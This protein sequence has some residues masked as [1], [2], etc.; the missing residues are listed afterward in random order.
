MRAKTCGSAVATMKTRKGYRAKTR[1]E[2]LPGMGLETRQSTV[3]TLRKQRVEEGEAA[4]PNET[5]YRLG[6][7][8]DHPQEP[9][10]RD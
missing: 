7:E 5:G 4:V 6:E 1:I 2:S 9:R 8:D 3:F 10:C